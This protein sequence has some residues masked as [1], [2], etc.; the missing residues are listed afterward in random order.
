VWI[1]ALLPEPWKARSVGLTAPELDMVGG[2]VLSV[3][4]GVVEPDAAMQR[5][6]DLAEVL[7]CEIVSSFALS[8]L[9]EEAPMS[10]SFILFPQQ[11]KW[12]VCGWPSK[13]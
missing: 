6:D 5:A 12:Y 9:A 3:K 4:K 10:L 8:V 2:G 1:V 13:A 7:V 11:A